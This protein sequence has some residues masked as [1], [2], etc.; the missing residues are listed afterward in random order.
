[1]AAIPI[2]SVKIVKIPRCLRSLLQP[3][4]LFGPRRPERAEVLASNTLYVLWWA[5][6]S[7]PVHRGVVIFFGVCFHPRRS[8]APFCGAAAEEQ[9]P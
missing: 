9:P 4:Q 5:T 1:M 6:I 3:L 2:K 7:P 8:R